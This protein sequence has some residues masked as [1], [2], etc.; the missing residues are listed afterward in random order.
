MGGANLGQVN[1]TPGAPNESAFGSGMM[2]G[3]VIALL[4]V[5][6]VVF[7]AF[8]LRTGNGNAPSGSG[9]PVPSLP[10]PSRVP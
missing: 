3:L 8:G 10:I 7:L 1:V 9:G 6:I 5:A 4:V 2:I